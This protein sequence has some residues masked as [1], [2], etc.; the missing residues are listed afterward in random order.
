LRNLKIFTLLL[1]GAAFSF[2]VEPFPEEADKVSVGKQL[3]DDFEASGLA[4]HW[5]LQKF[6]V[7]SDCGQL[8]SMTETGQPLHY[9]NT[10]KD[11][12]AVTVAFAQGDFIYLGVEDP[13]SICEFNITT[14]A[15]TRIFDL[16]AWMDGP[17][18]SGLEALTFV[19]HAGEAEGGLFYAGLQETGQI[20]VFRLP[21]VSSGTSTT[22]THVTTIPAANGTSGIS[23]LCYA[24]SQNALYAIYDNADLLRVM[25]TDGTIIGHWDLPGK[26]QEGVSLKGRELYICQDYGSDGGNVFRYRPF[27]VLAQ[28]DLDGDGTVDLRDLAALSGEWMG[29]Q[30]AGPSDLNGD[31]SVDLI[32]LAVLCQAW[33]AG[34]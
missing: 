10:G 19:P 9:W 3:P 32:D 26:D 12:E 16:T 24:P 21:I 17:D 4:W 1:L 22:V 28:P 6:F 29:V 15:I 20:F 30:V 18:N 31:G 14:G 13:D 8:C 23:D 2:G 27:A 33:L 5:R 25:E 11:L 34:K 7:V